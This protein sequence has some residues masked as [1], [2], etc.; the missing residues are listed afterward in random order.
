[1][2]KRQELIKLRRTHACLRYCRKEDV[3]QHV[4]FDTIQNKALIYKLLDD[5]EEMIILFNPSQ[6]YFTHDMNT[7]YILLY[8]N[9]KAEDILIQKV[10]VEPVSYTHLDVYKRQVIDSILLHEKGERC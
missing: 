10:N 8:Y 5:T 7:A 9:G 6:E 2:Y 1:M 4:H 3:E